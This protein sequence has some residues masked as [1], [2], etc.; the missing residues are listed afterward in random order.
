[1]LIESA[2][3]LFTTDGSSRA[4]RRAAFPAPNWPPPDAVY[5]F[6]STGDAGASWNF[7][8]RP[9]VETINLTNPNP[10]VLTD[11]PYMTVDNNLSSPFG[12]RS[13]VT[14]TQFDADGIDAICE[15]DSND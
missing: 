5:V 7:P 6:R 1:M 11:K 14:G 13:Y 3:G 12:V 9:A 8:G 4:G 15:G 2:I 10:A